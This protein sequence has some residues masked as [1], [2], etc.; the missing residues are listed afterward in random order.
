[1]FI[2]HNRTLN[3]MIISLSLPEELVQKVDKK[4]GDVS[5]SR[6]IERLL[7]KSLGVKSK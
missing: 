1:M 6:F 4:A 7:E 5:R 3:T 2:N